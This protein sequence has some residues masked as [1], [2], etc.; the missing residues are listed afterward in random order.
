MKYAIYGAGA[1]GTIL[2]A[3]IAKAGYDIDLISRNEAHIKGIQA[4]GAHVTGTQEFYQKVNAL[5]PSEMK[6]QYDIIFLMTKQLDNEQVVKNLVPYL[7]TDGVIC[8]MQNG[9]PELSVS[10]VIGKDRTFG[11]AMAWGAT[12]IGNGSSELTS[13]ATNETL[14]F[15]LGSFGTHQEEKL[16]T[17]K[18]L[19][20]TMG[21]VDVEE[22]FIGA[23]WAKLLVNSA[24]SG[25]SAVLG[26]TFG[27]IA[28]NKKS[29]KLVQLIIKECIEVAHA[30]QIKIEPIQ[31]KNIEKLLDYHG[32]IKKQISFMIIPLAI[33]KHKNLKSSML[34]D[35]EKHKPCEIQAINGVVCAYGDLHNCETPINDQIVQIVLEMEKG[36]YTP[37]WN[38]I[39][40]FR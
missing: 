24:F 2:G 17:I 35:I 37:S 20:E 30:A 31:G 23:R 27:E 14:S 18:Q 1:M 10:N 15:S 21:H 9:M 39:S 12:M 26:A 19:L 36:K 6:E 32:W 29:R 38:N 4:H 33:K 22:N 25:L 40:L 28:Q 11:S 3:Y 7:K 5:L 13:E 8:T 16:E 34:Q